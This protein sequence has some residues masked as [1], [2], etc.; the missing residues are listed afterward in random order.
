M[1]FQAR[2]QRAVTKHVAEYRAEVCVHV[3]MCMCVF[4]E[5]EQRDGTTEHVSSKSQASC[6]IPASDTDNMCACAQNSSHRCK[7]VCVVPWTQRAHKRMHRPTQR[8]SEGE[9]ASAAGHL[10]QTQV[11]NT[12]WTR[13][14]HQGDCFVACRI[15][16]FGMVLAWFAG[17]EGS[18]AP[19]AQRTHDP[20]HPDRD[21]PHRPL[22]T[23]HCDCS[24]LVSG[25]HGP[26]LHLPFL[27]LH[28]EFRG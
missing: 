11:Y 27:W 1:K 21:A 22:N 20:Q 12:I 13:M 6:I 23:A 14:C 28:G 25:C 17:N 16:T 26:D 8:S 9:P 7:L 4:N 5:A 24:S 18:S 2:V 3:R 15:L 19:S 10:T